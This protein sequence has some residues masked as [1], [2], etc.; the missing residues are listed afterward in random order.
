[1]NWGVA[2]NGFA[3]S[4]VRFNIQ[5][6]LTDQSPPAP[7]PPGWKRPPTM[8]GDRE[9]SME[10]VFLSDPGGVDVFFEEMSGEPGGDDSGWQSSFQYVDRGLKAGRTYQYRY[11]ARDGSGTIGGWSPTRSILVQSDTY[12]ESPEPL[13]VDLDGDGL[14]DLWQLRYGAGGLS[15]GDDTDGD[16]ATNAEEERM[17]TD[18]FDAASVLDLEQI[19]VS[20]SNGVELAWY[21]IGGKRYTVQSVTGLHQTVWTSWPAVAEPVDG[22]MNLT[23][24]LP[25]DQRCFYRLNVDNQDMDGDGLNAYEE[26]LAGSSDSNRHG[27]GTA[28]GGDGADV[29]QR[30]VSGA[31]MTLGGASV[32]TRLPSLNESARFLAQASFGGDYESIVALSATGFSGWLDQQF[33]LPVTY[34]SPE[35][36][37]LGVIYPSPFPFAPI[38]SEIRQFEW[39]NR[40]VTSPDVLRQRVGFALS[41]IFVISDGLDR[42]EDDARAVA[43]Y[44]DMLLRHA[45]GN[46]RN[47]LLDVSLHPAMGFYLSHMNN[48]KSDP[49]LNRFPDENYAREVMQLFSIGLHELNQDGTEK[50]DGNG[51]LIP[52]YSN[53]EITEMAKVFTG[54]SI[55]HS[56]SWFWED[57]GD[58][59]TNMVMHESFH[60]P[61][62]KNLL[63]GMVVPDQQSGLEDVEDA[64]DN[65]FHHPNVGPFFGRRLIQRLVTSNPGRGYVYRV[66]SAFNDNGQGVRGDMK[67]VLRAILLDPEARGAAAMTTADH[68]MLKEP[69]V[70]LVS[71]LR[72]FNATQAQNIFAFTGYE[73]MGP[74]RQHPFSSPSVFNFFSP[75][76]QPLGPVQANGL[77]APEFQITIPPT[78]VA[79]ANLMNAWIV[80]DEFNTEFG[81]DYNLGP[82]VLDLSDEL[83]IAGDIDALIDRLDLL[84]TAGQ[85]SAE[86]RSTIRTALLPLGVLEDRVRLGLYL[87]LI[88]PDYMITR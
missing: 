36:E 47:L 46:F 8:S 3:L 6:G 43:G 10:A 25:G 83:A 11:R 34:Q 67:A 28:S 33:A 66:A 19:R 77:V 70:R 18:P 35:M 1:D 51:M 22:L 27:L 74:M 17:G 21:L 73:F 14:S 81:E 69:V 56:N 32:A 71:L 61:G 5:S 38:L 58:S 79:W 20:V 31:P 60:E 40:A 55:S 63:N 44:G 2:S 88:S 24:A 49:A 7:D 78:I 30:L 13:R 50:R 42:L 80:E 82:I 52:T 86:S 12:G 29:I 72:T 9:V 53:L 75:D 16:G 84:L 26:A 45:F 87:T 57:T 37:R 65:L 4:E 62:L 54:L 41:E 76:Y 59:T 39:W 48:A 68:G 85:L 15:G 64:I 23:L